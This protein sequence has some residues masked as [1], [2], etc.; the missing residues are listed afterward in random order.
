MTTP[1]AKNQFTCPKCGHTFVPPLTRFLPFTQEQYKQVVAAHGED[2][3]ICPN[4]KNVFGPR[5][6][7]KTGCFIA[8]AAYGDED[9]P[10]VR[11][12]RQFRDDVLEKSRLGRAA[13]R[14]YYKL[15]PFA[16]RWVRKSELLRRLSRRLLDFLIVKLERRV[17]FSRHR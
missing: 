15:S 4:C 3:Q 12:L 6:G 13:V 16:V 5:S 14:L 11:F 10:E 17:G 8:T 1:A 9:L 2:F 7:A